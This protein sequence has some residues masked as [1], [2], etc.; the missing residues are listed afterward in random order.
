MS[1]DITSVAVPTRQHMR[2]QVMEVLPWVFKRYIL[3]MDI[4]LR[5]LY[6]FQQIY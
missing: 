2:Y 3:R 1:H 6:K 5:P 4:E